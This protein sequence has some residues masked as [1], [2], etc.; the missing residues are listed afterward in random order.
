MDEWAVVITPTQLPSADAV[1]VTERPAR[2]R[3]LLA[4]LTI[5]TAGAALLIGWLVWPNSASLAQ[6]DRPTGQQLPLP[7][8]WS[9]RDPAWASKFSIDL[10][11]TPGLNQTDVPRDQYA[12]LTNTLIEGHAHA[13]LLIGR[14]DDHSPK[15][16][17]AALE[18]EDVAARTNPQPLLNVQGPIRKTKVGDQAGYAQDFL[19]GGGMQLREFRFSD[20]GVVYG[21]GLMYVYGD[22]VSLDTGLAA[23]ASLRVVS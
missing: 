5:G 8:K 7:I 12:S 3:R 22:Q 9:V 20:N 1:V 23:I 21:I 18:A 19:T 10:P 2:R 16:P 4:G 15:S 11:E 17:R 6:E 13:F 14:A